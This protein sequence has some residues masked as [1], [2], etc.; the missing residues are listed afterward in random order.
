MPREF[1]I[2]ASGL[3]LT[4]PLS[5]MVKIGKKT[6]LNSKYSFKDYS[7][8]LKGPKI[9]VFD[10]LKSFSKVQLSAVIDHSRKSF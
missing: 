2:P 9:K 8:L 7:E 4:I 1:A 6:T 10:D 5:S 3:E